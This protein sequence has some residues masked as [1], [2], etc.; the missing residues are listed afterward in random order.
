MPG[1]PF[2]KLAKTS[3][4]TTKQAAKSGTRAIL[5]ESIE[6]VKTG[7]AQVSGS[8]K[9]SSSNQNT[10]QQ[11]KEPQEKG[12]STAELAQK[13][14]KSRRLMQALEEELAQIRRKRDQDLAEQKQKEEQER[15][16]KLQEEQEQAPPVAQGKKKRGFFGPK[17]RA[18]KKQQGI[19]TRMSKD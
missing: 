8:E 4:N 7:K 12:Y 17:A 6:F 10:A 9:L 13:N 18:Q 19:E 14:E 15:L 3:V 16:Q 2:K 1:D 5:D 11:D